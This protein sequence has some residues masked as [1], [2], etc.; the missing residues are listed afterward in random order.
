MIARPPSIGA[1]RENILATIE[2]KLL[3]LRELAERRDEPMLAYLID[4]ALDEARAAQIR[5]K[6]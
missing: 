3:E 1:N 2:Q 5:S 4:H 6:S